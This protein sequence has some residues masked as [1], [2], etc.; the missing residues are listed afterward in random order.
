LKTG[1][2]AA[3]FNRSAVATRVAGEMDAWL[4]ALD[5]AADLAKGWFEKRGFR[6]VSASLARQAYARYFGRRRNA[7]HRSDNDDPRSWEN[8]RVFGEI[9]ERGINANLSPAAALERA[10]RELADAGITRADGSQITERHA[11]RLWNAAKAVRIADEERE[12]LE[13]AATL[14]RHPP[15]G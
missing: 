1:L 9:V 6:R 4:F 10:R 2:T 3:E 8:V 13:L 12:R 14:R 15:L 7:E 11:E 5:E